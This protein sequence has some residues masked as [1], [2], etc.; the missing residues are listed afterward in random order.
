MRASTLTAL[1]SS[2]VILGSF[3]RPAA[4]QDPVISEFL[5]DNGGDYVDS[6]GDS[7]DWIEIH[8]PGATVIELGGWH[9]TD[10]EDEPLKWTI[11]TPT[12]LGPGG[13]IVI[14]ASGKDR[15]DPFEL[16]TNFKLSK[17]GEYLALVNPAGTA[18]STEFTPGFPEQY[19]DVSYG[20][21]FNGAITSNEYYFLTPTPGSINVSPGP[22]LTD[23]AYSPTEP[24]ANDPVVVSVRVI[25][26]HG[27]R[28]SVALDYRVMYQPP[29]G[30]PMA[31][32]G[33]HPDATADD[34]VWTGEIPASAGAPGEMV[35]WSITAL[36]ENLNST[37][38][39]P[40][41]DPLG[42]PE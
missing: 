25:G 21:E 32:D 9:L 19:E 39:P 20:F 36:D 15:V 16:H 42:S 11:P 34:G 30:V 7:S 33:V 23:A 29:V 12:W 17:E 24:G 6:D 3:T 18:A 35:R 27:D 40:F 4:A 1:G 5:A 22:Y 14:F 37:R 26:L 41:L 28:V 8:N 10:D 31:D 2:L 38:E 13:F